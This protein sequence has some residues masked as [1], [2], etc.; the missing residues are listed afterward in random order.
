MIGVILIIL[1]IIGLVILLSVG[2]AF[3]GAWLWNITLVPL[4]NFPWVEWWHILALEIL[5]WIIFGG[6]V[7]KIESKS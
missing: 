5:I 1:G 4:F 7:I 2:F 3:L 6:K